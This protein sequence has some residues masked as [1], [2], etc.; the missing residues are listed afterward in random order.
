MRISFFTK[1]LLSV[2]QILSVINEN[3]NLPRRSMTGIL[4]LF[5][6][7]LLLFLML[8]IKMKLINYCEKLFTT[9]L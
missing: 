7:Y 2:N 8:V 5:T 6:E 9:V 4:M 3:I 1:P